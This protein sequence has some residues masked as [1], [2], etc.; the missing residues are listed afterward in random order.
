M[1]DPTLGTGDVILLA[2]LFVYSVACLAKPA[3]L[4]RFIFSFGYWLQQHTEFRL[5]DKI[6]NLL[7]CLKDTPEKAKELVPRLFLSI[8]ITGYIGLFIVIGTLCG[9][10]NVFG[11]KK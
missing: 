6:E 11:S 3:Q 8:E 10:L 7:N 1:A 2:A 4:L 5:S 9:V